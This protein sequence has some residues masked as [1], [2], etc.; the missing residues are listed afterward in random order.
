MHRTTLHKWME[1][2]DPSSVEEMD[3]RYVMNGVL[4]SVCVE[5]VQGYWKR[6]I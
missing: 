2:A 6:E 3:V 1:E 5:E 4:P